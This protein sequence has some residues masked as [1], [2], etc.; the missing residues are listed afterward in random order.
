MTLK[1]F[2]EAWKVVQNIVSHVIDFEIFYYRCSD[3][4]NGLINYCVLLS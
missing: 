1:S 4:E 3:V 2:K